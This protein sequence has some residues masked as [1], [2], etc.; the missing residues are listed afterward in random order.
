MKVIKPNNTGIKEAVNQIINGEIIFVPTDTVYGIAANPYKDNAIKKIFLIKKRTKSSSLVLLCSNNK[1][2]KKY[3]V[4]NKLAIK[5]INIFWPGPL[6]LILKRKPNL[7]ISKFCLANNNSI[8]IRVP[9]HKVLKKIINKCNFPIFCTS[10]NISGK[11]SQ[12]S[13]KGII[14]NFK[15]KE[16]TIINDGKTKFAKDSTIIDVTENQI[17]ILREGC[18]NKKRINHSIL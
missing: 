7:K 16:I 3:G 15:N 18:I 8:G 2:A 1:M 10:A 14:K 13:I 9:D 11:K 5:L 12:T 6:T 17:N 4:F